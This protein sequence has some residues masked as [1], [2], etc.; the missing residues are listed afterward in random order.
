MALTVV[1]EMAQ[2]IIQ[3]V[4]QVL[5]ILVVVQVGEAMLLLLE[6]EVEQEALE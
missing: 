2:L 6:E 5:L 3:Q 1:V 4:N